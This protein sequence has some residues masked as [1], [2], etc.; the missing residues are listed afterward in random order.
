MEKEELKNISN[1]EVKET[2]NENV[3]NKNNAIDNKENNVEE[4]KDK[5]KEGQMEFEKSVQSKP[6][7]ENEKIILKKKEY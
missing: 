1:S 2:Q 4:K 6:I 3:L 7:E 5:I